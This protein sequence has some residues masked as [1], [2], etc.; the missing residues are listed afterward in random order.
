[1]R[2]EELLRVIGK[3]GS[4][5]GFPNDG[6][7]VK[8]MVDLTVRAISLKIGPEF[9]R[10]I[11]KGIA[12]EEIDYEL[13]EQII[14]WMKLVLVQD[15]TGFAEFKEAV[16]AKDPD[17]II[18]FCQRV[19]SKNHFLD[20][21]ELAILSLWEGGGN[22]NGLPIPALKQLKS[23]DAAQLLNK[24]LGRKDIS[25]ELFRQKVCRMRLRDRRTFLVT[26]KQKKTVSNGAHAPVRARKIEDPDS[27]IV[28]GHRDSRRLSAAARSSQFTP[29]LRR[30][31]NKRAHA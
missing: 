11:K 13:N 21:I 17:R 4:V 3:N 19:K 30:A 31:R 7:T 20:Q 24:F 8:S 14:F 9:R 27:R 29:G 10:R 5:Y 28:A 1:M 25:E 2:F 26:D 15:F 22:V 16:Q 18:N 23:P 12:A 6:P